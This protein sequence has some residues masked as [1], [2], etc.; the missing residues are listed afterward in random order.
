[1]TLAASTSK[2]VKRVVV[3]WR[4]Q[5]RVT[6]QAEPFFMGRFDWVRSNAWIWD[7][8]S[9]PSTTVWAGGPAIK[10]AQVADL[11]SDFRWLDNLKVWM[12]YGAKPWAF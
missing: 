7:F 4:M 6:V 1:M 12:R 3:L 2:A 5:L 8:S 11:G 10:A 9:T